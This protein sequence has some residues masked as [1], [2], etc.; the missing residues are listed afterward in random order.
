MEWVGWSE[1]VAGGKKSA[2]YRWRI[3]TGVRHLRMIFNLS[4]VSHISVAGLDLELH[5]RDSSSHLRRF[6]NLDAM[7]SEIKWWHE[8]SAVLDD[9]KA[10]RAKPRFP[11]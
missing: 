11:C 7:I 9:R 10:P 2:K 6:E 4:E 8:R 3:Q 1:A 5:F